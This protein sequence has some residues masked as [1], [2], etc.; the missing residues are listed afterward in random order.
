MCPQGCGVEVEPDELVEHLNS[1]DAQRRKRFKRG[2]GK[3]KRH[4]ANW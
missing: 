4:G 2:S 1:C 3:K